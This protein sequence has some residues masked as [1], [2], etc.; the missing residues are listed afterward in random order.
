MLHILSSICY[1]YFLMMAIVTDVIS[2]CS[3]DSHLSTSD[4]EHLFRPFMYLFFFFNLTTPGLSCTCRIY[5]PD[6]DLNPDPLHW[7]HGV[8]ATGPPEKSPYIPFV[9][10]YVFPGRGEEFRPG[11]SV[12]QSRGFN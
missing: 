8:L 7:E 3:V 12:T 5:L 11:V 10:D 9:G 4:V 1:L 6:Q 2:H